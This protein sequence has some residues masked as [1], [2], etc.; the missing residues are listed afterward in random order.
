MT[1]AA[2]LIPPSGPEFVALGLGSNVGDRL[3]FLRR[4]LFALA[5][6]PE[7]RIQRFS[8]I[9]ETEYVGPGRQ[10]PYLNLV[11]CGW[12]DLAPA[13]LLA[14]AKGL[15]ERLGRAPGGHLQPRTLDVDILMF[16]DRRGSAP[17]L[18]LP[19]PRAQQRGFVLAPLAE[20]APDAVFAD[21]GETAAAAWARIRAEGGPGLAPWPEPVVAMDATGGDEEAWRAALAVHCR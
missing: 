14:V 6:H 3:G 5:S 1:A 12:C 17:D 7:L 20:V 8:R 11:C 10:D 15:E 2:H 18:T 21:S 9:W 16:G 4:G 19:H 13:T